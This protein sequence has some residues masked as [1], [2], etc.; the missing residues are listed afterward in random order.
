MTV[1]SLD[2]GAAFN[3]CTASD[4]DPVSKQY[5]SGHDQRGAVKFH[6]FLDDVEPAFTGVSI[7]DST[8]IGRN[9]LILVQYQGRG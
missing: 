7:T 8:V 6:A 1:G 2:G 3:H 9:K 4:L 5:G